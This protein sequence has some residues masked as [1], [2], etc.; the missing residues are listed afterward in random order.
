LAS[1]VGIS[2]VE[3]ILGTLWAIL[4]DI[5]LKTFVVMIVE[6]EWNSIAEDG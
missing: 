1:E 3:I 2:D 4:K 5:G 6:R